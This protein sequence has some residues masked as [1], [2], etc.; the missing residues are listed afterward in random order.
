MPLC[1]APSRVLGQEPNKLWSY[2][3]VYMLKQIT[4]TAAGRWRRERRETTS[5]GRRVETERHA[6]QYERER[7]EDV[8][9]ETEAKW[10]T[11]EPSRGQT[12][13]YSYSPMFRISRV[14]YRLD[15]Q[16]VVRLL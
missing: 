5:V 6:S 9:D 15:I 16:V 11:S 7:Q 10:R 14:F 2:G 13:R 1:T 4:E 8:R 3:Y 12:G